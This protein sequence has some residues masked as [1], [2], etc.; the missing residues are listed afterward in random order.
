[1]RNCE[2]EI[3]DIVQCICGCNGIYKVWGFTSVDP[4][5]VLAQVSVVSGGVS[6]EMDFIDLEFLTLY[7]FPM[8]LV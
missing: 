2:F 6:G 4:A 8:R 3:G 7:A 5:G 1:M